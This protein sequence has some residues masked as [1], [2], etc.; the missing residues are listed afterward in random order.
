[1]PDANAALLAAGK[2][3]D[4]AGLAKDLTEL[5]KLRVSQINACAFCIQLHLNIARRIGVDVAKVEQIAHWRDAGLYTAR[6]KAALAWG[7]HLTAMS[8]APS[9]VDALAAMRAHFTDDEAMQLTVAIASINAW[10]RI[11]GGL[12]FPPPAAT[13]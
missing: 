10:N 6:E 12:G 5:V 7:E 1:M 4:D 8:E 3:V 9:S 11:S 2:A 13:G